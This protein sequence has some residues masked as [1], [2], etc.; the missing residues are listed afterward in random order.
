MS[1]V[2]VED[3]EGSAQDNEVFN[4]PFDFLMD[5][6]VLD[7]PVIMDTS[8]VNLTKNPDSPALCRQPWPAWEVAPSLTLS[9]DETIS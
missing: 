7:P 2:G 4:I 9:G 6:H 3:G 5:K 1:G 8:I